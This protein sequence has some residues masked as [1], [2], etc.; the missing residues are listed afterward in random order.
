M[1]GIPGLA[2]YVGSPR[3]L[4]ALLLS[5]L[6]SGTVVCP[7]SFGPNALDFDNTSKR[8]TQKVPAVP[9]FTSPNTH[10]VASRVVRMIGQGPQITVR[11]RLS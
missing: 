10:S 6:G 7:P 11:A 5:R 1:D 9:A 8:D 3:S 4:S 2:N